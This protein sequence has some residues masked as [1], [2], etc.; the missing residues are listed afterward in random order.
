MNHLR[1]LLVSLSL[2][3]TLV[4]CDPF[5]VT[6]DEEGYNFDT[7][8]RSRGSLDACDSCCEGLGG[9]RALV[10]SGTCGCG[11]GESN[12]EVCDSAASFT[13]CGTCCEEVGFDSTVSFSEGTGGRTCT[14]FRSRPVG[15]TGDAG[16][17]VGSRVSSDEW[18][19]NVPAT[20]WSFSTTGVSR[21]IDSTLRRGSSR[22]DFTYEAE[23]ASRFAGSPRS[24]AFVIAT[25]EAPEAGTYDVAYEISGDHGNADATLELRFIGSEVIDIADDESVSGPFERSGRVTVTVR[26]GDSFGLRVGG[27]T[28]DGAIAGA[29]SLSDFRRL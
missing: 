11:V 5:G 21:N 20:S 18:P 10:V 2:A 9:D 28:E 13:A 16:G 19:L 27:G 15:E 6:P 1:P 29:Y 25:I 7:S 17:P 3:L 23:D 14:C 8:C 4:A 26:A 24:A 22:L 12:S